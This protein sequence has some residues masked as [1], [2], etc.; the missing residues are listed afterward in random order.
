MAVI[1]CTVGLLSG[2]ATAQSGSGGTN[3]QV[4]AMK[5]RIKFDGQTITARLAD[6]PSAKDFASMLP[7]TVTLKDY[8]S[9]E[10]ITDLP[11]KL[12]TQGAPPG[13]DPSIGDIAYYAPWGNIAIYYKDF[14][15]SPGLISLAKIET[16]GELLKPSSDD[17]KAVIELAE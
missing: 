11:R 2:S 12:S 5:I 7:L 4:K 15:Y 10:K 17:I 6:N 8:A 1:A 3:Q 13:H 14:S 9:T 16:G